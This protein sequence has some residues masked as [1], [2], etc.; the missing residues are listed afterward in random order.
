V[1]GIVDITDV[2]RALLE[3]GVFPPST[4]TAPSD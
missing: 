4:G 2:C 1:V 3:T